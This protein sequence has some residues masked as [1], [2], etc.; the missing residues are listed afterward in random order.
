[1]SALAFYVVSLV[2]V[3]TAMYAVS[4]PKLLNA[5]LGLAASFFAIGGLYA[6]LGSPFLTVLQVLV[7]AGAIPIVTVFI[8]MMTQSRIIKLKDTL[9][10]VLALVAL[11]I[12]A[13]PMF[14]FLF[15]FRDSG[16]VVAT[17][18][19]VSTKQIGEILMG[20][21]ETTGQRMGALLAFEV[22]S[23][24]LL[25]AM[26]GA[27]VLAKRDGETI[28]GDVNI[29]TNID[30]PVSQGALGTPATAM[31]NAESGGD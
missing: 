25:V 18:N 10:P 3:V 19:P 22:A 9:S 8:I 28:K 23:V 13:L 7:N 31:R 14:A 30:T 16:A 29:L 26:I 4:S 1:M 12:I 6:L 2:V 24:I 20:S 21:P 15:R 5:A 17:A 27:I 11:G